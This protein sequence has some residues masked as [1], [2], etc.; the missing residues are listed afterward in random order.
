MYFYCWVEICT[1][2]A[3]CT[4]Q[5][6][7][8]SEYASCPK[9]L[10]ICGVVKQ[11]LL[12]PQHLTGTDRDE[13]QRLSPTWSSWCRWGHCCWDTMMLNWGTLCVRNR[14]EVSSL[15]KLQFP[16][17]GPMIV[18]FFCLPVFQVTV[19]ILSGVGAALL[20]IL[21]LTA[22]SSIRKRPKPQTQLT[23]DAQVDINQPK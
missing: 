23:C 6:T 5:C 20:L 19:Y 11:V 15:T 12:L 17:D 13:R 7:I 21:V 9:L 18:L 8:I 10:N 1:G 2:H 22:W 4:Q 14:T 3:D 16:W